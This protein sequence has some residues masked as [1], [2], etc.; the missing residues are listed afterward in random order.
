MEEEET[1]TRHPP[2]TKLLTAD[3][4]DSGLVVGVSSSSGRRS[5]S[6]RAAVRRKTGGTEQVG[7]TATATGERTTTSGLGGGR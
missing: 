4:S 2:V 3:T 1:D 5:S 7:R 6:G